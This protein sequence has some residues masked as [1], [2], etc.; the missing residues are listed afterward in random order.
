MALPAKA[1]RFRNGSTAPSTI[2][3]FKSGQPLEGD[4]GS[5]LEVILS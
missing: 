4:F 2:A 1:D 5:P 3:C